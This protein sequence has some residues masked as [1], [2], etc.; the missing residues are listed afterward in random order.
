MVLFLHVTSQ[1]STDPHQGLLK[2]KGFGGFPS[3]AFMDAE[4]NVV[5][6]QGGRT[7][8]AFQATLDSL[9]KV[10]ALSGKTDNASVIEL[11]FAKIGLGSL[12]ASEAKEQ[13]TG[14]T[15]TK[16]QTAK[17]DSLLLDEEIMT[18]RNGARS[19]EDSAAVGVK[20]AEMK[21]AGRIPTGAT[22]TMFWSTIASHAETT[23]DAALFEEAFTALKKVWGEDKAYTRVIES[24]N[25]RLKALK[26]GQTK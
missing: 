23:K 19:R 12:K 14:K 22:A 26:E 18:A 7:V 21:K 17:L 6:K 13:L 16:D 8:A 5:A 11:T 3:L 20:F 2:E 15:L 1:V 24:M 25:A 10:K 9:A 4:G